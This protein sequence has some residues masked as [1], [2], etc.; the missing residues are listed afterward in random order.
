M[1]FMPLLIEQPTKQIENEDAARIFSEIVDN[2]IMN[3]ESLDRLTM[4]C[5]WT[6]NCAWC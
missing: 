3:K 4:R 1:A 6:D 5:N 2:C